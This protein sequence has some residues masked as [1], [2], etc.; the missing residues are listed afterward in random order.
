MR[1]ANMRDPAAPMVSLSPSG[2]GGGHT[3]ANLETRTRATGS[4]ASK[5]SKGPRG[6]SARSH[7]I[8]ISPPHCRWRC[9]AVRDTGSVYALLRTYH[10][11]KYKTNPGPGPQPND[12]DRQ[13]RTGDTG[14]RAT[15]G[16]HKGC[17][18][19]KTAAP[20]VATGPHHAPNLSTTGPTPQHPQ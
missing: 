19:Q 7:E 18:R 13:R 15:S 12:A 1:D 20:D 14:D 10:F 17:I 16:T 3:R 8:A 5:G 2:V 11:A 9:R 4:V 6:L